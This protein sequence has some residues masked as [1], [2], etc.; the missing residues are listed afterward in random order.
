[1]EPTVD[2]FGNLGGT[3]HQTLA[4]VAATESLAWDASTGAT[5][6]LRHRDVEAF[7]HDPRVAGIGL[8]LFDLMGI[9][10]GPLRDWYGGLMFTNDG[11]MHKR[12]RSLV[13]RAFTPR[14]AAA[15]R[16]TAASLAANALM[17]EGPVDL[18]ERFAGLPTR[19]M[20]RLLGVPDSDLPTF[21]AW[22]DALSPVFLMMTP[23]QIAAATDAIVELCAYLDALADR[24]H[25][26]PGPDLLTALLAV[27]DAGDRMT[28]KEVVRMVANLLIAGHDTTGSQIGCTLFVVFANGSAPA[29]SDLGVLS[30]VVSETTRLEPAVPILPRTASEPLE[31]DGGVIPAGSMVMLCSVTANRDPVV[32]KDP[33]RFEP[34]RFAVSGHPTVQTFGAGPHF[35]LGA[36]LAKVTLEECLRAVV[37]NGARYELA[38]PPD[39]IPW[40]VMLG[41][42]PERLLVNA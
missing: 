31:F 41:R 40:R 34:A 15:L 8:N 26:D 25:E 9:T 3:L 32:W 18:V 33:D 42:S 27:E 12:L 35:C 5:L 13:A 10:E 11:E 37:T 19:V 30:D 16:P 2:L 17:A 22:L 28:R 14:S 38:E 6:V 36:A 24:R 20:C 39:E 21:I 7:A 23:H 4:P 1:M 29:L